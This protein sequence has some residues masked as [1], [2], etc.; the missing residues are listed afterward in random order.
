MSTDLPR[1]RLAL[2][3]FLK[4]LLAL[5]CF[6]GA[7]ARDATPAVLDDWRGWVL[8]NDAWTACPWLAGQDQSQP[9]SRVCAWPGALTIDAGPDGATFAQLWRVD[10]R[11]WIALPGDR[12]AWPQR[13]TANGNA[14]AVTDDGS[15][16]PG[17]WLEAGDFELAGTLPWQRRPQQ[18]TVP[19][20]SVLLRVSVD[21]VELAAVARDSEQIR[22]GRSEAVA[23]A[24]ERLTLRVFRKLVD[25][26]PALLET[27][28]TLEVSGDAREVKLPAPLPKLFA[29]VRLG[30]S[31]NARLDAHGVLIVQLRPGTHELQLLARSLVPLTHIERAASIEPWPAQ[32]IWSFEQAPRWRIA[33]AGGGAQLDPAQAGVPD[34]WHALPA[35]LMESGSD[36]KVEQRSRGPSADDRNRLS[37]K[38]TWWLDFDGSGYTTRDA[39]HGELRRDWRLEMAPP[40]RLM[41]AVVDGEPTQVT[42]SEKSRTGIEL[43]DAEISIDASSRVENAGAG[44]PVTGWEHTFD[45]VEGT[46]QLP[47]GYALWAA[48]GA[49]VA[50]GSWLAQWTLLAVFYV[51]I[52]SLLASWFGGWR[53]ATVVAVLLALTYHTHPWLTWTVAILLALALLAGKL[54]EGRPR[55]VIAL[56]RNMALVVLMLMAL[57]FAGS[58]LRLALYPQ[59]EHHSAQPHQRKGTEEVVFLERA[60]AEP[61]D[62]PASAPPEEVMTDEQELDTVTVTGSRIKRVD[63]ETSRP[64]FALQRARVE[65]QWNADAILQAGS[66]IPRW[67]WS[68]YQLE[69][70]GPVLAEQHVRLIISPP[71]LTRGLRLLTVLLLALAIVRIAINRWPRRGPTN[72]AS[73]RATAA[74]ILITLVAPTFADPAPRQEILDQLREQ[75]L[76]PPACSPQC[77]SIPTARVIDLEAGPG[78][79]LEAHSAVAHA[80][81]V[82]QTVGDGELSSVELDGAVAPVWRQ[83][84]G[85]LWI[86]VPRGVHRVLL[87]YRTGNNV[88]RLRWPLPAKRIDVAGV[89]WSVE[90]IDDEGRMSGDSLALTRLA[91]AAGTTAA[92]TSSEGEGSQ[93]FAPF[94]RVTREVTFGEQWQ[95]TTHVERIAPDRAG[96]TVEVPLLPGEAVLTERVRV[97]GGKVIVTL[98][99]DQQV[100]SWVSQLARTPK[101]SIRAPELSRH[102]EVWRLTAL[103]QWSLHVAGVPEFNREA[104]GWMHEFAPLPGETLTL[105]IRRPETAPGAT[106][107][108]DGAS[109]TAR[110]GKRA[111]DYSLAFTLRSTRGDQHTVRLP[112]KADV[113]AVRIDGEAHNLRPQQGQL[114]FPVHPGDQRIEVDWRDVA[115]PGLRV[116]TPDVDLGSDAANLDVRI[117]LPGDRWLLGAS[118]PRIGPAVLYWPELALMLLIA[119]GLVRLRRTPLRRHDWVLLGLGFSTVS[120]PALMVVAAWLLALDWRARDPGI[121]ASRWFNLAQIG[122]VLLTLVA[123]WNLFGAIHS[124]LLGEPSMHVSGNGSTDRSLAWFHDRSGGAMPHAVVFTLPLLAYKIAMLAW[125]LWLATALLRWLRWGV[126]AWLRGGYW[127]RDPTRPGPLEARA[128]AT[129]NG[130][131]PIADE[132][133]G[134][135]GETG[136]DPS[137]AT[138]PR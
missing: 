36:F 4:L 6:A 96:F 11:S 75:L 39:L 27:R 138:S 103:P 8:R 74:G 7:Q 13:V 100:T 81:P 72:V 84:D 29:P 56:L 22:L 71:W 9:G 132:S 118:G 14:V 10:A 91:S 102:A 49:D 41:R 64:K 55:V 129:P 28:M 69:W 107:A 123:L 35:F 136:P 32:E 30:G 114:V 65:S 17:V 109:L 88:L 44:L 24:P 3:P 40:Y 113:L 87:R 16:R 42:Q 48:P 135:A 18:L 125:A 94:V 43:R 23:Q 115:K 105:D 116:R 66:G 76:K 111:I 121:V 80:L 51:A 2:A 85:S 93:Q 122:L 130:N 131:S 110:I 67:N 79:D 50:K 59:L 70:S 126:D 120:W 62:A 98:D 101:L 20:A 99:N 134:S 26:V 77:A 5:T 52:A 124:G 108:V 54:P 90:G 68:A 61:A 47:P 127:H 73:W 112:V 60:S 12:T 31:L 95:V 38:R 119:I 63:V 33:Q 82:P 86:P 92:E 15:G 57:P 117:E 104:N 46:L 133:Q 137:D 97:R 25:G 89:G 34:E 128:D 21:G 83:P 58:Q 78:L 37:L 53:L 45:A 19:F 1:R 106:R